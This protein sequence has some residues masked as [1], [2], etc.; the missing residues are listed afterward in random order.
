MRR[1]PLIA[2]LAASMIALQ[3]SPGTAHA[4]ISERQ[5]AGVHEFM[6]RLDNLGF[7]GVVV[8]SVKGKTVLSESCGYADRER[9]VPWSPE[10]VSTIGSITKHMTAVGIL[11]LQEQG[12]LDVQDSIAE[13]LPGVPDDKRA[14]TIHHL[15]IHGSGIQDPRLSDFDAVTRDGYLRLVFEA[16]L[17]SEPGERYRYSNAGYSLLAAIIEIRSGRPYEQWM[18]EELFRPAG[19]TRTGYQLADWSDDHL[20]Q[21]YVGGERWGTVA[22]RP[23]ADDGPYWALRGNGGIHMPAS[24]MLIWANAL[25]DGEIISKESL[26][27]AWTGHLD[28]SNGAGGDSYYG[29]GFAI[30][31]TPMGK[32]VTHN[33]G[34]GRHGADLLIIP[35]RRVVMFAQSNVIADKRYV[36]GILG[37][38]ATSMFTGEPLPELPDVV[39]LDPELAAELSGVYELDSGGTLR[40]EHAGTSLSAVVEGDEA[41]CAVLSSTACDLEIMKARSRELQRIFDAA[42]S[43]DYG[44]LQSAYGAGTPASELA[45][46]YNGRI[47]MMEQRFGGF[48]GYEVLGSWCAQDMDHTFIRMVFE[49]G[50][51]GY[52]F[53]WTKDGRLRG[54]IPMDADANRL[55]L[56]PTSGGDLV[57][58]DE[59][60]MS[61]RAFELVRSGGGLTIRLPN[62]G[63][64]T[65]GG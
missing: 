48:R 44:A 47:R 18:Q 56:Y 28:E 46:G 27:L 57:S 12:A 24:E 58:F 61:S 34:N 15:L 33:G 54:R 37:I 62:G 21:A 4:Q 14:I 25:L 39:A 52:H 10:V 51:S 55:E 13:H 17:E 43:G 20:A 64:G 40:I 49:N 7:D 5:R 9:Q 59:Q 8:A 23:M 2:L 53:V 11:K 35:G 60:S 19:L 42:A 22:E 32:I 41:A 1:T 29:Y 38:L 65:K 36:F 50:T 16:P 63:E 26:E 45:E 31:R 3:A 30:Q 6:S